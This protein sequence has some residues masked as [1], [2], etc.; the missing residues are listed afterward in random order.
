MGLSPDACI[1][2]FVISQVASWIPNIGIILEL[3]F[4]IFFLKHQ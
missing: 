2:F 4:K 3:I 1:H